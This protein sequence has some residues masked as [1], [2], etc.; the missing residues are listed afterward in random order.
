MSSNDHSSQLLVVVGAKGG[1]GKSFF[2]T[3]IAVHLAVSGKKVVLVDMDDDG[4]YIHHFFGISSPR[5]IPPYWTR[6]FRAFAKSHISKDNHK[7]FTDRKKSKEHMVTS[8]II[9][10]LPV[11]GL[12]L[13]EIC[14]YSFDSEKSSLNID[15]LFSHIESDFIVVDAGSRACSK[16]FDVWMKADYR[17]FITVAEPS[18]IERT[19]HFIHQLILQCFRT[20][21]SQE[22]TWQRF[23]SCALWEGTFLFPNEM[24]QVLQ[25]KEPSLAQR[26]DVILRSISI[27]LLV[28]QTTLRSDLT[29]GQWM[30]RAALLRLR[31]SIDPVGYMDTDNAVIKSVRKGCPLV[32]ETLGSPSSRNIQ[33]IIRRI[34]NASKSKKTDSDLPI[35]SHHELLGLQRGASEREIRQA[36]H[37]A[38]EHFFLPSL[39]IS[40]LFDQESIEQLKARLDEAYEV[41]LDPQRR[42]IYEL[43][44]FDEDSPPSQKDESQDIDPSLIDVPDITPE[45][46]FNGYLLR[47]IRE[48]H[49]LS[50]EEISEKIKV[51]VCLI[52]AIEEEDYDMLPALPYV[53]GFVTELA[54]VF[55]LDTR[56][57]SRTYIRRYKMYKEHR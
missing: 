15:S 2:S 53:R 23:L 49:G 9:T 57:V 13:L 51:G 1:V 40:G 54:K 21:I 4:S 55:S 5:G 37:R 42:Q 43:S 45:T 11:S 8:P 20:L 52:Q 39:P 56:Q 38:L 36:Y 41:L 48:S 34:L 6:G 10:D 30:K 18:S 32:L 25:E 26:L 7:R 14:D 3:N 47:M 44:V 24:M 50:I 29:I 31:V 33:K 22:E 12:K 16:V 27:P 46:E 17:V 28:N 35:G 19:Y